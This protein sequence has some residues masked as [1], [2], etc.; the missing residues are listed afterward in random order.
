MKLEWND[1]YADVGTYSLTIT[2]DSGREVYLNVRDYYSC[3]Y[4]Q[5]QKAKNP[6][7]FEYYHPYD[8]EVDFG[9]GWSMQKG[10]NA[11]EYDLEKVKIWAEDFL[12]DGLI[13]NYKETLAELEELK[14][15][16][17]QA[18]AIKDTRRN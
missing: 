12:L 13:K 9:M 8:F 1:D 14:I 6:R 5:T 16:A 3:P 2:L 4:Q 15:N 7:E 17:E 11:P 10:F 18:Q